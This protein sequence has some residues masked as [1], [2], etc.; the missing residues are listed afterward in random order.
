M[1]RLALEA[2]VLSTVDYGD[3][4]RIVT[5]F[6]RARGK[7]SA[8][9]AGARKSKRRFAGAFESGTA[10]RA[11]L[12]ETRGDTWRVDAVDIARSFHA[13][14][15]DLSA[16]ARALH[17]LELC[18]ELLRD[19]QPHAELY[20]ALLAYLSRLDEAVADE[21]GHVRFEI[22]ALSLTGFR[23]DFQACVRCGSDWGV[24]PTFDADAGGALCNACA[25]TSRGGIA[26][27][28]DIMQGLRAVQQGAVPSWSDSARRRAQQLLN[29][30]VAH[31]VGRPL[32]SVAFMAQVGAD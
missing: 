17:A 22:D 7:L 8:F 15:G 27:T 13:T 16:I 12:V 20:D 32:K 31:H 6:T 10:L 2:I 4:D 26:V 1:E 28:P 18:R 19:G 25:S 3:A 21:S 5:L 11:Q 9:A 23:P 14:R 24:G 29:L 30:F